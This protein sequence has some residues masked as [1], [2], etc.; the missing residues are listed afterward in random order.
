MKLR[1]NS[2]KKNKI[3][4]EV[5]LKVE[6]RISKKLLKLKFNLKP[7]CVKVLNNVDYVFQIS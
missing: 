6:T 4:M 2:E 7:I 1:K 3:I 5:K